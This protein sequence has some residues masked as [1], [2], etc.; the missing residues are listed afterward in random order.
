MRP[1]MNIKIA[2]LSRRRWPRPPSPP[3]GLR[4]FGGLLSEA[5]RRQTCP[6]QSRRGR[7]GREAGAGKQIE[8]LS[9]SWGAPAGSA[10]YG[11][12]AGAHRDE[13]LGLAEKRQHGW[14]T[15]AA[16]LRHRGGAV[17]VKVK[18]PWLDCKVGAAFPDAVLQN[19]AGRYEF[20]NVL[21]SGCAPDSVTLDYAKVRVRGW[22]PEKKED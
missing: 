3:P 2:L 14:V 20:K 1:I 11:A 15:V 5:R 7:I 17:R 4:R 8:I 22:D 13:G 19:D 12:V 21:I 9:W 10:K 6:E 18:F 16:P